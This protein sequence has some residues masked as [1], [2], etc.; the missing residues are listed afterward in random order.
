MGWFSGT[1]GQ[2]AGAKQ[3][4]HCSFC[5]KG[6]EATG[7]LIEGPNTVYICGECVATCRSVLEVHRG[8]AAG[9][10][11]FLAA[12][13][14]Y[15]FLTNTAETITATVVARTGDW[16]QVEPVRFDQPGPHEPAWINLAYVQTMTEV[17]QEQP[18]STD[19]RPAV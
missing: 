4:A 13:T 2:P 3:A 9:P 10:R 19:I 14:T 17:V 18:G 8:T 11:P 5:Q 6:H 7:P 15:R 16:V 12:G 1:S